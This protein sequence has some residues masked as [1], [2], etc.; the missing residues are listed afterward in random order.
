[1]PAPA[2]ALA[3]GVEQD[4]LDLREIVAHQR[5]GNLQAQPLDQEAGGELADIAAR[6]RVAELQREP[7]RLAKIGAPVWAAQRF[8]EHACPL[9]QRL[10]RFEQRADLD[11][12]L[13][14]EQ[15]RQPERSE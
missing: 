2:D 5:V 14:T 10:R 15:A 11:V 9:L 12:P 7:P 13:D 6:V 8:L 4:H 3:M 1:M